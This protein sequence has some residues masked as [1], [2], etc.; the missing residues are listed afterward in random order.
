M[1]EG[2]LKRLHRKVWTGS[3]DGGLQV[4]KSVK[5]TYLRKR[6]A[7]TAVTLLVMGTMMALSAYAPGGTAFAAT[8][9]WKDITDGGSFN[10]PSGVAV[11]SAG[12]VFVT[13]SLSNTIEELPSGSSTWKDITDG[14]SF[15]NP[16]GI[17][18]DGAGDVFVTNSGSNTIEELPHGSTNW[19]D[20]THGGPFNNPSGIAVDSVGNVFVTNQG[21]L[22]GTI[23][24]RKS[25]SSNWTDITDGYPFIG[26]TGVAV[27]RTGNV[28]VTDRFSNKIVELASGS[29]VW[30]DATNGGS[31][32]N[33]SGIAVDG[34]GD[35][36]VANFNNTTSDAVEEYVVPPNVPTGLSDRGTTSTATT[37]SW[38]TGPGATSYDVYEN[39]GSTPI[40]TDVAGT[41]YTVGN[42]FPGKSYKFTVSAVNASGESPQSSVV[43][44]NTAKIGNVLI[45]P[46]SADVL[47]GS[48][49]TVSGVVYDV[50]NAPVS[51]AIVDL[52]SP[53]GSFGGSS[54]ELVTADVY[55]AFT[56]TWTAPSSVTS[57]TTAT[58]T[59]SVYG[60]VYGAV[61]NVKS[62]TISLNFAPP[63][64]IGTTTLPGGSVS[65]SYS[66][67]LD[68][69]NGFAPYSWSVTK[70]SL[71]G[72]LS[73]DSGTGVIS[74]TP[75][76]TGTSDF[77]VQVKDAAGNTATL[78]LST[79][80]SAPVIRSGSGG[81][82]NNGGT[83][84][85]SN[86]GEF[87][88]VV[89][90]TVNVTSGGTP[91]TVN[92]Q[93]SE[94]TLQAGHAPT[95]G[96]SVSITTQNLDTLPQVTTN[97]PSTANVTSA[98]G[99]QYTGTGFPMTVTISN[100]SIQVGSAVDEWV[101]GQL[102]QVPATVENG[103]VTL[104]VSKDTNLVVVTPKPM[105]LQSNQREV[106]WNG[107]T[108]GYNA[109]VKAD[110]NT[111][112]KTTYMP[113]WYVMQV[114]KNAGITSTWNGH[115]WTMTTGSQTS[116]NSGTGLSQRGNMTISLNGQTN[117]QVPGVVGIDLVHGNKTTYMPIWYV[118]QIL[119]QAGVHSDW[120]GSMWALYPT[121]QPTTQQ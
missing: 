39:G 33:P 94:V 88:S 4:S 29:S 3:V 34:L 14:G 37:L 40:A 107:Q 74:G 20:I 90:G 59:A 57:E 110:P 104:Q 12:D 69:A 65:T 13:N 50:Y 19:T 114:L 58:V 2:G 45:T 89:Q 49:V 82:S 54:S 105:L 80:V 115:T 113:I 75:T 70:G 99:V 98:V 96:D 84:T 118:M 83:S 108:Y 9:T 35:M 68:A 55:G 72:G 78:D 64:T 42:L 60:T 53:V 86:N 87:S 111:G 109:F 43:T 36:F 97:L 77:T 8:G 121:E 66:Q 31:L 11:D 95:N 10:G 25:G 22:G 71:P 93:G 106:V 61:S 51:Y 6:L 81:S 17:A 116:S 23:V 15:N 91:E 101:N 103:K 56:A 28:F 117:E 100:P 102:V 67:T 46:S 79:T 48:S 1:I 30:T 85:P 47:S 120:T 44:V 27:D 5:G 62:T 16:S 26:P 21:E 92:I 112:V 38:S 76:A 73:L 18:V 52:S 7:K 41:S 32:N 63:P 24:E 119:N